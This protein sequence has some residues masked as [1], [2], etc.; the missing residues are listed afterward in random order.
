VPERPSGRDVLIQAIRKQQR[1]IVFSALMV[2][3]WQAGE[4]L[5]PFL[6]GV[7]ID[8]AVSGGVGGLLTWL[9]A[10]GAVY[11]G[12]SFSYRFGDRT[13]ERASQQAAHDLRMQV[14]GRVLHQ[15]GG[16]EAGR[17]P[18]ALVNIAT[19]DAARVGAVNFALPAVAA[20]IAGLLVA[21]A[22]LLSI[23]LPLG[24]LVL[25]G[26]PPMLWLAH[27]LGRP[28]EQRSDTEQEHAAQA[29]G[30]AADLIGG[31]RVLKGL[32]A[33]DNALRRYHRSSRSALTATVRAARAEAGYR[34]LMLALNGV[35]IAAIALVGGRLAADGSITIGQLISAVGL[36]QFLVGPLTTFSW[37]NTDLAQGRASAARVASVLAAP[38]E[39]PPGAAALP[40]PV[41]GRIRLTGL[42]AEIAPGEL[43]GVVTTD[44]AEASA[45]LTRLGRE[46]E[47]DGVPVAEL[48][49][50]DFR[51]VVLV[52]AH[53]ADLFDGT[54]RENVAP[55]GAD[56]D[57]ALAAA[58]ADEVARTLPDGL[59]T[60]LDERGRS[61]S[62]GQR[63][64]VA[65]A[66]AL[67]AD[68]VVLVVHDPTTAV[69]AVTEAR[70]AAGLRALRPDR[71]TI[72]V[73]TSPALLA[74]ADRVFVVD[75]G[76]VTATGRHADLVHE[77]EH[78]RTA[79][80]T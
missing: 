35:F 73:T 63:Q 71:T 27:L 57:P 2:T 17:L 78:Y 25:L 12:L 79:V 56:I 7:V 45:V 65:L 8:R 48:A 42:D 50:E 60:V 54:L 16:A 66:R 46:A 11:V 24:L 49:P 6:I 19:G 21:A 34:G 76:R 15:R 41:R 14:T 3:A 31:L 74:V 77:H 30:V 59:D 75:D 20:A 58:A 23:S 40:D 29:S 4:A 39:L 37:V 69:D 61:L 36:A 67:A 10:L 28:L 62:G 9:A 70:I 33:E 44:P 1:Y 52:A 80:L 72:M 5:V 38:Y 51:T 22:L 26:S 53:D 32:G 47:L 55:N 64:R 43:V 13:A 18:G 68:P